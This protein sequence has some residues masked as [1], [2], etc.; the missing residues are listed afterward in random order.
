MET[1][2]LKDEGNGK[3]LKGEISKKRKMFMGEGDKLN[4]GKVLT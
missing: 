3:R 2:E 4:C 1:E